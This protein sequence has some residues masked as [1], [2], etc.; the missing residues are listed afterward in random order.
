[1]RGEAPECAPKARS[2]SFSGRVWE[3]AGVEHPS[4][5]GG[6]GGLTLKNMLVNTKML[7][8][9]IKAMVPTGNKLIPEKNI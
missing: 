6:P 3:G 1:M 5:G 8:L 4:I 2:D 7:F 9:K